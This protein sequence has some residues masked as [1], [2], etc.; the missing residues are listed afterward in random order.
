MQRSYDYMRILLDDCL[1]DLGNLPADRGVT[2]DRA[3]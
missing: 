2:R 3:A 1:A